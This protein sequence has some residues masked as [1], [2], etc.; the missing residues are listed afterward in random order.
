[1]R[2]N[3]RWTGENNFLGSV[4]QGTTPELPEKTLGTRG[5]G[6][7]TR[8][9]SGVW[10]TGT[11][12]SL[13]DLRTVPFYF[14][15]FNFPHPAPPTFPSAACTRGWEKPRAGPTL[16]RGL[17][18]ALRRC[19][20]E[21]RRAGAR[22]GRPDGLRGSRGAARSGGRGDSGGR[23]PGHSPRGS[24]RPQPRHHALDAR[25]SRSLAG[26]ASGV[27][28]QSGCRRRARVPAPP[29]PPAERARRRRPR[30]AAGRG[31]PGRDAGRKR[32]RPSRA[33]LGAGRGSDRARA[34]T[35]RAQ[36]GLL[37]PGP[38]GAGAALLEQGST[39]PTTEPLAPFSSPTVA[40]SSFSPSPVGSCVGRKRS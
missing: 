16:R 38:R 7:W 18:C 3:R 34:R 8:S 25:G 35:W 21:G 13:G 22:P 17:T 9:I 15:S 2:E 37:I 33:A 30:S 1:M 39:H 36:L 12:T 5:A 40:R 14:S 31:A 29:P 32:P 19:R 6:T 24:G 28:P 11:P 10:G 20:K 26:G 23:Q 27:R 4:F